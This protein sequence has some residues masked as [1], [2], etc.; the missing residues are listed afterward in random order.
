[1]HELKQYLF[2]LQI[3][4]SLPNKMYSKGSQIDRQGKRSLKTW[5]QFMLRKKVIDYKN[6]EMLSQFTSQNDIIVKTYKQT[7]LKKHIQN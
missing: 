3:N 6:A 5:L 2:Y 4:Q 1:M 7:N